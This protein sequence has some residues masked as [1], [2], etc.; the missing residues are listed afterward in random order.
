MGNKSFL[1]LI[2]AGLLLAA[3][4]SVS[5]T[6][7]PTGAYTLYLGNGFT[8]TRSAIPDSSI[9]VTPQGNGG[10]QFHSGWN[11]GTQVGGVSSFQASMVAFTV[12]APAID[13][14][15][16]FFNGSQSGTGSAS[17]VETYCLNHA[18]SGCPSSNAGSISVTN[19]PAAFNAMVFFAPVT[20]VAVSKDIHVDSGANGTANISQAINKF[21][22]PEPLSFLLLGSGLLGL[23][24]LRKKIHKG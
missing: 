10:F 3:S 14:L 18:L 4:A 19:P 13:R 21:A 2:F 23:G 7:C 20:S 1:F 8:C 9:A 16:L 22:S 17:V 11:A 15:T 24:L 5:P 12:S 6:M